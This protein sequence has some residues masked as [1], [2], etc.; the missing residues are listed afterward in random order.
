MT[1]F[2]EERRFD[3]GFFDEPLP[4]AE[5]G[6]VE[7]EFQADFVSPENKFDGSSVT[8]RPDAISLDYLHSFTLG[9]KAISDPSE[10]ILYRPWRCWLE[11]GQYV[12]VARANVDNTDW[13]DGIRLFNS[14]D[15]TT[16]EIKELD[17]AFTQNADPVV[18]CECSDGHIWIY[19]YNSA[20]GHGQFEFNDFGVGR[21]PRAVLD[22][23]FD[24]VNSDVQIFYI[25]GAG[26]KYRQQRDRY[27]VVYDTP[28]VSVAGT[29]VEDAFRDNSLRLHVILS[30]R[31]TLTGRYSL[32]LLSSTLFP[33]KLPADS[34]TFSQQVA[35]GELR[36]IY[37]YG[38]TNPESLEFDAIV[39]G[40]SLTIPVIIITGAGEIS[41]SITYA[42]IGVRDIIIIGYTAPEGINVSNTVSG[43]ELRLAIITGYTAP[44]GINLSPSVQDSVSVLKPIL[45]GYTAAEGINIDNVV[46]SGSLV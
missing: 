37:I 15:W 29:Y 5:D 7:K 36:S 34:L 41:T 40:G 44:E 6:G 8:R 13:E 25:I 24:V 12:Y 23:P 21:S 9:P 39:A 35:G 1:D 27:T 17:V 46:Q 2:S 32:D 38:Y 4:T 20:P 33:L 42:F 26:L 28:V 11:A 30:H 18:C 10:G 22:D 45:I 31:N 19:F 14:K 16:V 3:T 43:G